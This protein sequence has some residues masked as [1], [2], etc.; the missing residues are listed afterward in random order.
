VTNRGLSRRSFVVLSD[1]SDVRAAGSG[2]SQ[3]ACRATAAASAANL[4]Q[5]HTVAVARAQKGAAAALEKRRTGD[6]TPQ[7]KRRGRNASA[8]IQGDHPA[9]ES[10][11]AC[12]NH[13]SCRG[14][15]YFPVARG[16]TA[17]AVRTQCPLT[18]PHAEPPVQRAVREN[19]T[20]GGGRAALMLDVDVADH[21]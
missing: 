3:L 7:P 16:G 21:Q 6:E 9:I 13:Q 17:A 11:R 20:N 5:R 2:G 1:A 19:P 14:H 15:E 4:D 8:R 10:A 18:A 12:V